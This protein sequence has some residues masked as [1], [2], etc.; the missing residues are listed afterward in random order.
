[1]DWREFFDGGL[2][3]WTATRGGEMRNFHVIF[4]IR[5]CFTGVMIVWDDDGS[6]IRRR[7]QVIHCD[8]S[9]HPMKR[10]ELE[11]K[12]GD[13][14]EIAQWQSHGHW[15]WGGRQSR[16]ELPD[17]RRPLAVFEPF[18]RQSVEQRSR[19]K[20][21]PLKLYTNGCAP[22]RTALCIQSLITNGYSPKEILIFGEH[23]WSRESRESLKT[24]LPFAQI[25]PTDQ[26]LNYISQRRAPQLAE[27]AS[28]YWFVMKTCVALLYPPEESCMLDD[29]VF[30]LDNVRDALAAFEQCNFVF[31]RDVDHSRRYLPIWGRVLGRTESMRTGAFNAG[32]Y[33]LRAKADPEFWVKLMLQVDPQDTQPMDWEQGFIALA[34]AAEPCVALTGERY[35]YPYYDGLPG[36]IL[37][38]D[39]ALNPCGFASLHFGGLAEKPS[40]FDALFLAPRILGRSAALT[41]R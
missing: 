37:G 34:H 10:F 33:W 35:F 15:L 1:V 2:K 12:E 6:I 13:E 7:G 29:D 19:P 23:Q 41:D 9:M 17:V 5:V 36:G 22:I 40:D 4:R 21:P 28:Q 18:I 30:I 16:M 27:W 25:V 32:L 31:T 3:R 14:L 24:L 11:V 39:Y 38:Y 8:R 20:G 26:F